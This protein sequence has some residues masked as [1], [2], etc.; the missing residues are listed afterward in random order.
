L[1]RSPQSEIFLDW[2]KN[3]RKRLLRRL[4]ECYVFFY[5]RARKEYW[6]NLVPATGR[7][8]SSAFLPQQYAHFDLIAGR[9]DYRPQKEMTT[10][11]EVNK[12]AS[13]K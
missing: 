9:E 12:L 6:E 8:Y 4:N 5:C 10:E 7:P 2:Q 1:L 13:Q 11:E 3:L